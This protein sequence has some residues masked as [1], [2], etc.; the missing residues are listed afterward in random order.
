[1]IANALRHAREKLA[2]VLDDPALFV[3]IGVC[4]F[5]PPPLQVTEG[6]RPLARI[7]QAISACHKKA[8]PVHKPFK[9]G[10]LDVSPE[11]D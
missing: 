6:S 2:V 1:M 8:P 5:A 11:N 10:E 7:S 9:F 3:G 4:S